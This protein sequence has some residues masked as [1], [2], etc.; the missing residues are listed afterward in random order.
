MRRVITVG[1]V[2]ALMLPL[3][4]AISP[5]AADTGV[6]AAPAEEAVTVRSG[7][8]VQYSIRGT[9]EVGFELP[10]TG[11]TGFD[12]DFECTGDPVEYNA[13]WLRVDIVEGIEGWVSYCAVDV[14]GDVFDTPVAVPAFP[15]LLEVIAGLPTLTAEGWTPSNPGF[16]SL[17]VTAVLVYEVPT[18]GSVMLG[19]I[20]A[21]AVVELLAVATNGSW[22]KVRYG[23]V[24]GWIPAYLM[25]VSA[26]QNAGLEKVGLEEFFENLIEEKVGPEG[27]GCE[28]PP[29]PWAPAW[30]W[31]RKCQG[32]GKGEYVPEPPPG[33]AKDDNGEQPSVE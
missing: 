18:L 7:P 9:L 11:H 29:P 4:L 13:A 16:A 15:I 1:I 31:R 12:D 24:V 26:E 2:A 3:M 25:I 32:L 28:S 5:V 17:L 21:G 19:K 20:E 10:V 14:T 33:H 27:E 22:F 8:G 6:T 23:A 30:G